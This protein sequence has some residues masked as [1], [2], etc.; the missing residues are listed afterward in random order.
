[1][2]ADV[3]ALLHVL[4]APPV[5]GAGIAEAAEAVEHVLENLPEEVRLPE[6]LPKYTNPKNIKL[7]KQNPISHQKFVLI[8]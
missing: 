7:Q 3:P 2:T 6:A 1:M 8:K 5:Q 4:P